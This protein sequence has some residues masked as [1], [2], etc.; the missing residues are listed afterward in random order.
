LQTPPPPPPP[1][2][3]HQHQ[4]LLPSQFHEP[5]KSMW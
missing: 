5:V 2:H 4:H 3:Q 1:P